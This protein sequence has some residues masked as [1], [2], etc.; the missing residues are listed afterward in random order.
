[1]TKTPRYLGFL[2][3]IPRSA[4]KIVDNYSKYQNGADIKFLYDAY[5]QLWFESEKYIQRHE[6][7][8]G[9]QTR[10]ILNGWMN[11]RY[12]TLL[13]GYL[14]LV[15]LLGADLNFRFGWERPDVARALGDSHLESGFRIEFA[16]DLSTRFRVFRTLRGCD[17]RAVAS[18]EQAKASLQSLNDLNIILNHLN[19]IENSNCKSV[20][21]VQIDSVVT[22]EIEK[23]LTNKVRRALLLT[24]KNLAVYSLMQH[25]I[26]ILI[27][28][29]RGFPLPNLAEILA[30]KVPNEYQDRFR[31]LAEVCPSEIT[32]SSQILNVKLLYKH[33]DPEPFVNSQVR[34]PAIDY[35]KSIGH[36]R[37]GHMPV[38]YDLVELTELS[39]VKVQKGG[40]IICD[41]ELVVVDR[42]ADPRIENVSGQ[43]DHVFG[44]SSNGKT[45]MLEFCE[46]AAESN[47]NGILLSGR[48]DY[49]WYHWMVEYLPRVI[50]IEKEIDPEIPWV[51]SNRVPKTGIEALKMISTRDIL[52]CDSE[53]LQHFKKLIVMS[54]NASVI[55]TVL[56]PWERISRFN[57]HNLHGL[58]S[59]MRS[60]SSKSS[61]PEKVFIVRESTHRNV[62]NQ[63]Q[64]VDIARGYGFRPISIENQDFSEQLDLFSNAK[65]IIT[66]GGAVMANYLFMSEGSHVIQLNNEANK[67]F[68]IPPLLSSIAGSKFISI[69]G[70]P[71]KVEK[72]RHLRI[73]QIHE[74]YVIKPRILKSVLESLNKSSIS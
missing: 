2:T 57:T 23:N 27:S 24:P 42:A 3:R 72:V 40:T 28:F 64:L 33:C 30:S 63:D 1:V 26:D 56:A 15:K 70:K 52:V 43:W 5:S 32:E 45:A 14:L 46:D 25:N 22:H 38:E 34:F 71:K 21:N 35:K 9:L 7:K 49:N 47:D 68:V 60:A 66:A 13:R 50:E 73:D 29:L 6:D 17:F 44:S 59:A 18:T 11:P 61:F 65:V 67:D 62:L 10:V 8:S 19:I 31:F 54:P 4:R 55:D 39:D 69:L 48:N 37:P 58:R 20:V 16:S 74:S 41:H 51:I 53:K 36:A 12:M